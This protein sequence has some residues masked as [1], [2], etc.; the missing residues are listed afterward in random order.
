MGAREALHDREQAGW[1][2]RELPLPGYYDELD[3]GVHTLFDDTA[4][5]PD[6]VTSP[7]PGGTTSHHAADRVLRERP[8]LPTS[9]T[10][11]ENSTIGR[12]ERSSRRSAMTGLDALVDE[13]GW[14]PG[15]TTCAAV[16][17]VL[18][19]IGTLIGSVIAGVV[20]PEP[21]GTGW[22][23]LLAWSVVVTQVAAAVLLIAGGVRLAVGCGRRALVTGAALELWVCTGYLLHALVV[24]APDAGE[25][26]N[27]ALVFVAVPV[28]VAAAAASALFLALRPMTAEYLLLSRCVPS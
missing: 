27:A 17:S 10:V 16:L 9:A 20:L 24:V 18:V 21:T 14:R 23:A 5:V 12:A 7:T 1:I 19:G 8:L 6:A 3:L 26:T 13:A 15:S 4:V 25:P 2:R 28:V 11:G 22:F